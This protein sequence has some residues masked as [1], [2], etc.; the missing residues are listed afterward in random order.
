MQER[1]RDGEENEAER[2]DPSPLQ[3]MCCGGISSWKPQE[4]ERRMGGLLSWD[5]PG[6][7]ESA[8]SL[9]GL[10]LGTR[11]RY[12]VPLTPAVLGDESGAPGS[13]G[14]RKPA[15]PQ[16]CK[17]QAKDRQEPDLQAPSQPAAASWT[18]TRPSETSRSEA[19]DFGPHSTEINLRL[20]L[21]APGDAR[22]RPR[23]CAH[24]RLGSGA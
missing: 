1:G 14:L 9:T 17:Q 15:C 4:A 12:L 23:G 8:S 21:G 3:P 22:D 7:G 18:D 13:Q 2:F 6:T 19:Q 5:N 11:C 10:I 20:R 24:E 16:L